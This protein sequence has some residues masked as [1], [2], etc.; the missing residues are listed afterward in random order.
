MADAQAAMQ[1]RLW[2]IR[3]YYFLFIGA[4][5]FLLPFFNLFLARQGLSGTQIGTIGTISSLTVLT[6]APLWGR[7][8]DQVAHPRRLLQVAFIGSA[9][10]NLLISQQSAFIWLALLVCLDGL[11]GAGIMPISDTLALGTSQQSKKGGFGSIRLW[12]SLGWAIIVML[13]GWLIEHTSF[14]SAF[15]GYAVTFTL[16][17]LVI[18]RLHGSITPQNKKRD[19]AR[20]ATKD[21]IHRIANDRALVGLALA[22]SIS[23]LSRAGIYQFEAIFMNQLGAGESLIGLSST[24]GALIE[25]P[26]MLWADSLAR[27]HG[28][29][30]MLQVTLVLH[31]VMAA[32]IVLFPT[33]STILLTRAIGG[34]SFSFYSVALLSFIGE[35]A[36]LGQTATTLALY[37][38]T[39]QGMIS[40][41]GSPLNGLAFDYLGAYWFYVFALGGSL[42]SWLVFS[43]LATG[44]RSLPA[45]KS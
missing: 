9:I 21:V 15:V 26:A 42:L 39:L 12:G 24:I 45:G 3:L 27:R 38:S 29:Y 16:T 31:A 25:L 23:W 30:W 18:E 20:I 44:R 37:T 11:A 6:A 4:G 43:S 13:S 22:L 1:R 17:A 5:G 32:M 35:R 41:F 8:G 10:L 40:I 19:Q 33:V 7:W 28:S 14:F 36:P 34:I 2:P